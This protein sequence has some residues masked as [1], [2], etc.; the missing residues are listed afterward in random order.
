MAS[1]PP[2]HIPGRTESDR[3][4][5]MRTAA[6]VTITTTAIRCGTIVACVGLVYL[7]ILALAGKVTLASI[8]VRL[9]GDIRVSDSIMGVLTGGSILY[10]VGQRQL[11]HRAVKRLAQEKND[12][13]RRLDP[14]RSSS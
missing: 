12:L 1:A 13:E 5:F 6:F 4:S 2:P 11:R 9:L 14:T 7:S 3:I 10:G 8:G